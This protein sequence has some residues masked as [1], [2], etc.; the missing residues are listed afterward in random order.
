[1]EE[2]QNFKRD[3]YAAA[4]EDERFVREALPVAQDD[5]SWVVRRIEKRFAFPDP[6]DDGSE[7]SKRS[8][9]KD[10]VLVLQNKKTGETYIPIEVKNS[11]QEEQII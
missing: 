5:D 4:D 7:V 1:M 9:P 6:D 3:A 2:K 10:D 11:G 8:P